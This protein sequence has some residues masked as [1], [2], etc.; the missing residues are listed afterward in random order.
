[1]AGLPVSL[2]AVSQVFR[3]AGLPVSRAPP[4]CSLCRRCSGWRC[5]GW[6]GWRCSCWLC[7]RCSG[8]RWARS[9]SA[10]RASLGASARSPARPRPRRRSPH[11]WRVVC[12]ERPG[13]AAPPV[14]FTMVARGGLPGQCLRSLQSPLTGLIWIGCGHVDR[15]C[16]S[17]CSL[18]I[19]MLFTYP[20]VRW[21]PGQQLLTRL[22]SRL[23]ARCSRVTRDTVS[24]LGVCRVESCCSV[25]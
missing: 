21:W 25:V 15:L 3:M 2:L 9:P 8:R 4:A 14:S 19:R 10:P 23:P 5:S 22:E 20:D 12:D 16:A 17:G 7:H 1:M 6:L 13:P 11:W 24:Y 18:P